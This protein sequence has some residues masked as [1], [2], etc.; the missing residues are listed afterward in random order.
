MAK[1][2]TGEYFLY[3]E[4]QVA[5]L[6]GVHCL[7]TL[8][9][10]SYFT[11]IDLMTIA[12]EF[13]K[14]ERE[15][16]GE[17]GTETNEFLKYMAED[18]GNVADDGNYSVQVLAEALKVWNLMCIPLTNPEVK[19]AKATP[20]KEKAFI[21]HLRDHWF[22]IRKVE[23]SWFNFDSLLKT[24]SFLGDF[25]LSLFLDT[26]TLQG[27]TIF[28]VRGDF[29]AIPTN[30]DMCDRDRGNWVVIEKSGTKK[31]APPRSEED[32]MAEAIRLSLQHTD[33]HKS[34]A[35]VAPQT[36][37]FPPSNPTD[38]YDDDLAAAIAA[39]L[40]DVK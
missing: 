23:D 9:Q 24:P 4:K 25:Y 12:Q 1:L 31:L 20:T 16:M 7:N 21:C 2:P 17:Y 32:E 14:K 27:Y 18:S 5:G 30:I 3:H 19:D 28:V 22:T 34:P 11:E 29:P 37:L 36:S 13:D 8:L 15:V 40:A 10:G 26:L 38:D 39:S 6:C 35:V 33:P